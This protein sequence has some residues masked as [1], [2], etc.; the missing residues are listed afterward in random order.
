M[1]EWNVNERP[2]Y[3]DVAYTTEKSI[4][5]ELERSSKSEAI[6]VIISY[7]LMFFYVA[8]ALNEMKCSIKKYFVSFSFLYIFIYFTYSI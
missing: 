5:D 1:K 2:E 4:E 8:F 3:M 7:M 6:T